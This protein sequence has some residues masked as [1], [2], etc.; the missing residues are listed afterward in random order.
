MLSKLRKMDVNR[1][2]QQ[3]ERRYK[4]VPNE[5]HRIEEYLNWTEKYIKGFNSSIAEVEEKTSNPEDKARQ[6]TQTEQ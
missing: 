4:K 3:R 5:S 2:L 1:E 6:S